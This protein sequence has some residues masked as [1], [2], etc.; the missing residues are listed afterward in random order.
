MPVLNPH[1]VH[2]MPRGQGYRE[3]A[4]AKVAFTTIPQLE[5]AGLKSRHFSPHTLLLILSQ[6]MQ[7]KAGTLN[8]QRFSPPTLL[9]FLVKLS[10]SPS[11]SDE[12]IRPKGENIALPICQLPLPTLSTRIKTP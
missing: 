2:M 10:I 12:P 7:L 5:A 9:L 8:S 11:P 3:V 1:S 6:L 4:R